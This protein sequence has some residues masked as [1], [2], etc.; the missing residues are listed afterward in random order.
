METV[1]VKALKTNPSALSKAFDAKQRVLITRCGKPF[2]VATP[3]DEQ[4][5]DLGIPV[6]GLAVVLLLGVERGALDPAGAEQLLADARANGFRL[7]ERLMQDSVPLQHRLTAGCSASARS[8]W[9]R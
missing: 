8:A 6:L 7:S 5:I 3:F 4:L 9:P 2:G 1:G